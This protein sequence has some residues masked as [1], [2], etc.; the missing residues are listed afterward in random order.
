MLILK[1]EERHVII[2]NK[3]DY[4]N[5]YEILAAQNRLRFAKN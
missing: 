3:H 4:P 5:L 1:E 2:N